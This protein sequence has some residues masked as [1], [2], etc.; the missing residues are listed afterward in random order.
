MYGR[1]ERKDFIRRRGMIC[2][3]CVEWCEVGARVEGDEGWGRNEET[4][5]G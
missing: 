1:A 3:E 4:A 2:C 5:R